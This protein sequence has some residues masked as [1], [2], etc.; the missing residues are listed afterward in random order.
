MAIKQ[1]PDIG[2]GPF[3]NQREDIPTT[4]RK[5]L[6]PTQRL[7]LFEA[8]SGKCALCGLQIHA[9]DKWIDEHLRALALGGSNDFDNRAPVHLACAE[10]KT[11][12][13][14]MP[15]IVKA[16][17]QKMSSLGIKRG[18]APKIESRGFEPSSKTPRIS[19]MQL[20]PKELY[21]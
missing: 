3:P 15:R 4:K 20:P 6:T 12:Q 7:K 11:H 9:G 16:K 13:Q 21:K 14:D 5:S 19:K 10:A 1:R 8:H 17:R 2:R 18:T